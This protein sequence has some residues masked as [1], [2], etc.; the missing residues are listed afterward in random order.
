MLA[1]GLPTAKAFPGSAARPVN[2]ATPQP[3]LLSTAAVSDA[4]MLHGR[5]LSHFLPSPEGPLYSSGSLVALTPP[6]SSSL[7]AAHTEQSE[8]LS[9][10]A[11]E[12]VGT[13]EATEEA[14]EGLV[15]VL[16][17]LDLEPSLAESH[18]RRRLQ[19]GA[20]ILNGLAV[21]S[22]DS[23]GSGNYTAQMSLQP[24][25]EAGLEVEE[26]VA[27]QETYLALIA[28][29]SNSSQPL[30]QVQSCCVT[31]SASP[32][33]PGAVCCL[34]RRLPFECRHIQ[35]LQS[36]LPSSASFTIQLFQMLNHS[37]AYLHCELNVCLQ[38]KAG[39]EQDCFGSMEPLLQPSDRNSHGKLHNLI[40]LG[41][42][43]RV[44]SRS[45]YRPMEGPDSA[46]LLPI[47][48]GSLTG[49]AIL[50]TAFISLWLHHRQ[51]TKSISHP[52][53]QDLRG[54]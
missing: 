4:E 18:Q 1:P 2:A 10:E 17:L 9:T 3:A 46:M 24:V 30:L 20:A 27:A 8:K 32:G 33:A 29:Q 19:P 51:K 6:G 36:S 53:L 50:G 42:V 34:F 13:D 49:F 48:L 35:L 12:L 54:L 52:Q 40:S 7:G 23:C 37:V 15:T 44:S 31:P 28:V 14:A 21:V 22:D 47:L 39:C 41:P 26:L 45:L 43:P 38:G 5:G 25:A 16:T 11:E